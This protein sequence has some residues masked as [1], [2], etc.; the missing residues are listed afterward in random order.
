MHGAMPLTCLIDRE[1]RLRVHQGLLLA[2]L[3]YLGYPPG[4]DERSWWKANRWIFH[5]EHDAKPAAAMVLGW[6]DMIVALAMPAGEAKEEMPGFLRATY[7]QEQGAWGGDYDFAEAYCTL[8]AM[9]H[10]PASNKTFSP[11]PQPG[12]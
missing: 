7:Y 2:A 4:D 5:C 3:A 12:R 9:S 6:S 10:Q 11:W 1:N 8:K